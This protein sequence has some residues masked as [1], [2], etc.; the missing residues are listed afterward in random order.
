MFDNSLPLP[1]PQFPHKQKG[2]GKHELHVL[3]LQFASCPGLQPACCSA[4]CQPGSSGLGA[5]MLHASGWCKAC[6]KDL[7][8][9]ASILRRKEK[10]DNAC[11]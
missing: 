5:A 6:S 3:P 7:L 10:K 1:V 2:N 9:L 8:S 11:R 4:H